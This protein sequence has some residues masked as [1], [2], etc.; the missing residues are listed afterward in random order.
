MDKIEL[1]A[2]IESC[3]QEMI[4]LSDKYGLSALVVIQTSK[5]LDHLLNRLEDVERTG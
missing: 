2:A 4:S 1:Q 5:H 3:R